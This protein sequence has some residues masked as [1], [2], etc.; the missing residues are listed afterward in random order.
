MA[1]G[2][3]LSQGEAKRSGAAGAVGSVLEGQRAAMGVGD[4]AAEDESDS[5]AARLRRVERD[6]EVRAAGQ[7]GAFVDDRDLDGPA[8][9]T[10]RR[11]HVAAGFECRVDGVP[12]HV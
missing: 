8:V 2:Y 10:P 7:A 12:D 5:S 4:L 9:Q 6:E 1:F 11:G 3:R